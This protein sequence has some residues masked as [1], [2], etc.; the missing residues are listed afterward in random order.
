[1]TAIDASYD[2][3][4]IGGGPAGV[5]TVLAA[6]ARQPH[7]RLLWCRGPEPVGRG[8]LP[9]YG[10]NSLV[11]RLNV[12]VERMGLDAEAPVDFFD[13]LRSEHPGREVVPGQFVPRRWFGEYLEARVQASDSA[14][15]FGAVR[16]LRKH[17][18]VW[19]IDLGDGGAEGHAAAAKTARRVALCLGMPAGL[20][21]AHAPT[22][23]IADPWAWWRALPA[24]GVPVGDAE[25]VLVV[26]S[27][28]TAVDMVLGL[29]ERGFRGRIRVVSPGGRWS[30]AHAPA[31]PLAPDVR[32]ALDDALDEAATARQVLGVLREFAARHPWRA[33]I[34]ALRADTNARWAGLAP[35]EQR[36]VLRH[37]FGVWNRHRHRMAPDVCAALDADAALSLESGRIGVDGEG[38]ILKRDRFGETVLDVALALDCRGPGFRAALAGDSLLARL[39]RDGV[40]EAHPLGTGVRTPADPSLTVIGAAR[41]GERFETSAVPELR[42]QAVEVVRRWVVSGR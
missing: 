6:R 27:G 1:M 31:A 24:Q 3:A 19:R 16:T 39:V 41:F 18:D 23:W 14:T 30:Q 40:L 20:P 12:P 17:D 26:G 28:L 5:A 29:R 11:H 34:D 22:H 21:M 15:C 2:L 9:A 25:T 38:R 36:R 33:V 42:Q 4:V 8:F 32:E 7:W 13:W 37:A 10:G 35:D